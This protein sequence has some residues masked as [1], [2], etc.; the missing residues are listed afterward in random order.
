MSAKEKWLT[1]LACFIILVLC[2][3]LGIFK[4]PAVKTG[5]ASV[6]ELKGRALGGIESRMPENSAKIFYESMLGVKL[7]A[8]KAYKNMDEALYALYTGEVAALAVPDVMAEYL[9]DASADAVEAFSW[10]DPEE[11]NIGKYALCQVETSGAASIMELPEGRFD[12]GIAARNDDGGKNIITAIDSAIAVLKAEHTLDELV[13]Y[14]ITDGTEAVKYCAKNMRTAMPEYVREHGEAAT[15]R[16]GITG[17][18]P[19]VELID[20]NGEPYGF[21]VAFMDEV[22]QLLGINV[23]FV[24]LDNETVFTGLMS[25][26]IDAVF[27]Y[28]TP[29]QVTTEG[30]RKW[31]M[32]D[33]YLSCAGYELI[34]TA[35]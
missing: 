4:K 3:G 11:K 16:V 29:G 28:G 34:T 15:L 30:A 12:F 26:G 19:P 25:G 6:Q 18:V 8:Y 21:C 20:E 13:R 27:C 17:S 7:S 33:G 2:A 10:K 9:T 24:V 1:I 14:Y 5:I 22:A 32:S 23:E 35:Q 31:I